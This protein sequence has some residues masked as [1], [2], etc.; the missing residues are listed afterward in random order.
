MEL[1]HVELTDGTRT[2]EGLLLGT[3]TVQGARCYLVASPV[4]EHG[5]GP[6]GSGPVGIGYI[7][8]LP[9]VVWTILNG[10]R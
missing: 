6:T 9:V 4:D 10:S 1:Q 8:I 7:L 5:N 2:V 3:S